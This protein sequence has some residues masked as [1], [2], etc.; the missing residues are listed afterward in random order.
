V[1]RLSQD[2]SLW[3]TVRELLFGRRAKPGRKA[4]PDLEVVDPFERFER[5]IRDDSESSG[6]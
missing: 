1:G 3:Q 4:V 6:D 5:A 2:R